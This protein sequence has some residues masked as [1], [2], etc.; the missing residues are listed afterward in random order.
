VTS[1]VAEIS[2]RPEYALSAPADYEAR[3]LDL[4]IEALSD[5]AECDGA[6]VGLKWDR[7]FTHDKPGSDGVS[8]TRSDLV[9]V[10]APIL[11]VYFCGAHANLAKCPR[12][13]VD[14]KGKT[15][16]AHAIC[17]LGM[18]TRTLMQGQ[19]IKDVVRKGV[20]DFLRLHNVTPTPLVLTKPLSHA[21]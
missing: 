13:F 10:V 9:G 8:Q 7:I 3:A 18:K 20:E 4:A 2:P 1:P 14:E 17:L 21:S 16:P 11:Y 12:I 15:H 6:R 19:K 5:I